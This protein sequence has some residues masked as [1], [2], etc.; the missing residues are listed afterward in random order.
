LFRK[1]HYDYVYTN[2]YFDKYAKEI[3]YYVNVA[4]N[5]KVIKNADLENLRA[6]RYSFKNNAISSNSIDKNNNSNTTNN[7]NIGDNLQKCLNCGSE[8]LHKTNVFGLCQ[9][10][11]NAELYNQ[12]M[13]FYLIFINDSINMIS[14]NNEE[15]VIQLFNDCKIS[16]N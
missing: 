13:G 7:N 9:N 16:L 2:N 3:C 8:Y 12:V 11:L 4:E 10:C 1:T 14:E 15:G 5:L 6:K